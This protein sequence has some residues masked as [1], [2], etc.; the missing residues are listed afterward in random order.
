MGGRGQGAVDPLERADH[1]VEE[2]GQHRPGTRHLGGVDDDAAAPQ[3]RQRRDVVAVTQPPLDQA[4]V[5]RLRP[6]LG[7]ALLVD[8]LERGRQDVEVGL[9]EDDEDVGVAQFEVPIRL[10]LVVEA[11]DGGRGAAAQDP[12]ARIEAG[13]EGREAEGPPLLRRGHGMDAQPGLGDDA[14]RALAPDEELGQIRAGGG[15]RPLALGVHDAAVGQHHL[16]ADHHVLDLPVTGRVLPRPPAGEPAADGG[17][18]HRL[19]PVAE[20]VARTDLAERGLEVGAEGAG[21]HVGRERC[22]VELA[23]TGQRGHVEGDA[24]MHGDGAAAHPAPAGRRPSPARAPRC[25]RRARPRPPRWR[26]G[27]PPRQAVAA[28]R[29]RPPTRWRVATSRGPP[30][31]WHRR[32]SPPSPRWRRCARAAQA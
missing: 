2:V 10:R 27:G 6:R 1:L 14:Q 26:K 15:A 13:G 32:R 29:P 17:E 8:D 5:Q 24:A 22:L 3:W 21:P 12:A 28:P 11:E 18:I 23:Q 20:R 4:L 19:G 25:R 7:G 9:V 31:P 30:R 16:E